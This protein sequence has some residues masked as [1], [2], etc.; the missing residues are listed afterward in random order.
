M[1]TVS[2]RAVKQLSRLQRVFGVNSQKKASNFISRLLSLVSRDTR[3]LFA[4]IVA[5]NSLK[6]G[7]MLCCGVFFIVVNFLLHRLSWIHL[8]YVK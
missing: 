7:C 6:L 3:A 4:F 2:T 8:F 1:G 5:C